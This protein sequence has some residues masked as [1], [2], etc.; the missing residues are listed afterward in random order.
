MKAP[1]RSN[2]RRARRRGVMSTQAMWVLL[3]IALT[4]AVTGYFVGLRESRQTVQAPRLLPGDRKHQ[5]TN[6]GNAVA[7]AATYSEL[8]Y[9]KLGP[10]RDWSVPLG[11]LAQP[12]TP[13]P[14][15]D[16]PAAAERELAL[17]IR[18][19]HRAF[20]GAPPVIPHPIL[21]QGTTSCL[22]CHEAGLVVG[23]K[24]AAKVSHPLY[25]NC[26]Q[27]HVEAGTAALA[28]AT[29]P[30]SASERAFAGAPPAMP[31]AVWMRENCLS[32]HG[33]GGLTGLKTTHPERANCLQ[34]HPPS[35]G[36]DSMTGS[37]FPSKRMP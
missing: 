36:H 15:K 19:S 37:L 8:A 29:I 24:I 26:T 2:R 9:K 13:T 20:D 34:C 30:K 17:K 25:A 23:N 7:P 4:V 33:P 10:N 31:H 35:A 22:A 6:G 3:A 16:P 27:C 32:C 21:Q 28:V 12:Q 1:T 5:D 18:G 11:K 14:P